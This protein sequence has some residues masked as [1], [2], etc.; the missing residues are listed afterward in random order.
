[1]YYIVIWAH[2]LTSGHFQLNCLNDVWCM[3]NS[4]HDYALE[5]LQMGECNGSTNVHL[6][7]SYPL[8][9]QPRWHCMLVLKSN[10]QSATG[11]L[12]HLPAAFGTESS[13]FVQWIVQQKVNNL[14]SHIFTWIT[15][16]LIMSIYDYWWHCIYSFSVTATT[17]MNITWINNLSVTHSLDFVHHFT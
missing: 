9:I 15:C 17:N 5:S 10:C 8:G 6:V 7:E 3:F 4:I 13:S 14:Y 1:M 2:S 16:P 12:C 11:I